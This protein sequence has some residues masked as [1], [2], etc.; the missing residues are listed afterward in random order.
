MDIKGLVE[1]VNLAEPFKSRVL[2]QQTLGRTRDSNT[3]YKDVVDI[4]FPQ[5]RRFYAYKKPVFSKYA[6]DCSEIVI[7]DEELDRRYKDI[8]E[9]RKD[10]I[11]PIVFE[12]DREKW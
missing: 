7:R 12:D 9:T 4:A 6:V 10:S 2:A 5:M 8:L 11:C 3:I 1:T